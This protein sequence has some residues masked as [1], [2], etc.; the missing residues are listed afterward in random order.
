MNHQATALA[1]WLRSEEGKRCLDDE[2]LRSR[3][4]LQY[5]R[6]R[7]WWAFNAGYAAGEKSSQFA[8]PEDCTD[9]AE[10]SP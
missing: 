7:L 8:N 9:S 6:N 10:G 5:L 4:H 1:E 3:E 2:I